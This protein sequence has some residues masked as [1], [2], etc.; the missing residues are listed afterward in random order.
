MIWVFRTGESTGASRLRSRD[1]AANGKTM[2]FVAQAS[3]RSVLVAENAG[4]AL[5]H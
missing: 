5:E 2:R 1:D 3:S 4:G